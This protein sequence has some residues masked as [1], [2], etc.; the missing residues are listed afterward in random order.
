M[1]TRVPVIAKTPVG[2]IDIG[3]CEVRW[4]ELQW[5]LNSNQT[6]AMGTEGGGQK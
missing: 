6:P 5:G 4:W 2:L 3:H 1:M